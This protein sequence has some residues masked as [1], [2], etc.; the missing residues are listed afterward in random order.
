M[1]Q[2]IKQLVEQALAQMK[3]DDLLPADT[4]PQLHIER[5]RDRSHGDFASNVAM[6]LAKAA[7]RKPREIAELL[8]ERLPESAGVKRVDIAGPGFINFTLAADAYHTVV[9]EIMQQ[10]EQYGRSTIGEGKSV[11]VEYVSANP[12]GP[13]HV[14]HGRGA[15]YGATVADLLEAVGFSVHRE[16]YVN[17]AGRQM[18]ILATSVWLRYLSLAGVEFEFPAN[19]YKGEYVWDIAAT[20]HRNHDNR[21]AH[22]AETVF[23]GVPADEPA[24]GDK[25]TH[26]D[27]LIA[28]AKTLLGKARY[29]EVFDL[30]LS[31]ILDDIRADLKGFGVKYEEWFSERSLVESGKVDEA[32]EQLKK[33]GHVYEKKGA[34]WFRS[35]EFG[36][37]KDRVVVRDNGIKT[38]FASDIAYHWHKLDRG[39]DRVIDIW[40]ADHHGYVPRV[41]A[42]LTAMGD[43]ED[44][45]KL[46]VLLVQFASLFRGGE[47]VQMSTRSG[48]FVTLR[49]LRQEVGSDAARFFYVMRKCEQ[50]MDFDLDLAKSQS[51]DNPMYYIQYAHARVCSVQ[52]QLTEKKLER[53]EARGASNLHLLHEPHE[54]S[55]MVALSRYPELVEGAALS[56]EPHQ[57]A[58]YLRELANEFHTYY[59]AH[60]FLIEDQPELR[61]A[62]LNLISATRQV[63]A[64]G[65][66]LLGISAP[67]SM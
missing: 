41:K 53:D 17:D 43:K 50:H 64:N 19:G 48:S 27:G 21:L 66:N 29:R 39:F 5:T 23:D 2:Q 9:G 58:H 26:I 11:Q 67:E 54:E 14:G 30:G 61:D 62:R 4:Q 44:A 28:R 38:Y 49:E 32:I 1:K 25:E 13:L 20:L 34:L 60:P 37:E 59:N 36:D 16:Y 10:S 3:A 45:D 52:R 47:K 33:S 7:R 46:D 24:G 15:A 18:D 56:H 40:G 22:P 42:A 51:N 31:T 8:V 12:T 57:L 55:L 35:T 6:T 65:L 63:L